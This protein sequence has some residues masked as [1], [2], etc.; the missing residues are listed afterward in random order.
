MQ[1]VN[2]L[3]DYIGRCPDTLIQPICSIFLNPCIHSKDF[4]FIKKN[5]LNPHIS[6]PLLLDQYTYIIAV[7]E[8]SLLPPPQLSRELTDIKNDH[9]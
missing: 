6:S 3:R 1:F 9:F 4:N 8:L 5:L 2:F 7:Y